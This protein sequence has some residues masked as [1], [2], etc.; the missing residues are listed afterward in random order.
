M[1]QG[2]GFDPQP[3]HL[4]E[5]QK[6]SNECRKGWRGEQQQQADLSSLSL[7]LSHQFKKIYFEK[8]KNPR[9]LASGGKL[10]PGS[11]SLGARTLL[12]LITGCE[13]CSLNSQG[14]ILH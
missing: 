9:A 1:H 5:S 8:K 14:Y 10:E 6:S 11:P 13:V 2:F 4:E 7:A 3:C 12:S